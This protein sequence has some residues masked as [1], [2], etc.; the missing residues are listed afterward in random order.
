MPSKI[1]GPWS[2][3]FWDRETKDFL[4]TNI[5]SHFHI[6]NIMNYL[7]ERKKL[8]ALL[9]IYKLQTY[10][11]TWSLEH[12]VYNVH[13][14][15]RMAIFLDQIQ[16]N[17][18]IISIHQRPQHSIMIPKLTIYATNVLNKLTETF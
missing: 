16:K 9:C 15:Y 18:G 17:S 3:H 13:Y 2:P 11:A 14:P 1:S 8:H 6:Q 5:A 12:Q 7:S 4:K 10:I